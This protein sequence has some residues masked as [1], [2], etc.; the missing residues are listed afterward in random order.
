MRRQSVSSLFRVGLPILVAG[1]LVTVAAVVA[2]RQLPP[3]ERSLG[4]LKRE[5]QDFV[6]ELPDRVQLLI[7]E[8]RERLEV[9]K[10]GFRAARAESERG[11][12]AQLAEAKQRGSL[13]PM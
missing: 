8:G 2:I 1:G 4:K 10:E 5:A 11:L 7:R 13:P 9:A 6:T 3:E 12:L